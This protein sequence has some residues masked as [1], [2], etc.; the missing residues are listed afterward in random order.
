MNEE[1]KYMKRNLAYLAA[2][3]V[4]VGI[5]LVYVFVTKSQTDTTPPVIS[6]EEE[7]PEIS[8]LEQKTALLR[9]VTAYDDADGD[10]TESLV[11]ASIR[12]ADKEGLVQV[13]YAA[14]D[15]SGNVAQAVRQVVYKDYESPRFSLSAPLTLVQNH[16]VDIFSIVHAEDMFDGDISHRVR[17]TLLEGDS[18]NTVGVHQVELKVT[19]SLG[20]T[21]CL[22]VPVE[23]YA[24]GANNATLT[25]TDYF[26]YLPATEELDA[27]SYLDTYIKNGLSVSLKEG[28]PADYSL[29]I[30]NNVQYGVP[31][32]YTVEYRVMQ[33]VGV[34]ENAQN[35][36]GY[37]KLIVVVEG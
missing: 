21:V 33:T 32:V 20:E 16:N 3:L 18:I 26:V 10:V 15:A 22:V 6:F 12:L 13:T 4:C 5:F 27:E 25:L 30:E 34:G 17:I 7:M 37:A 19:N 9:G 8:A 11:V 28:L 23:V 29:E 24:S 14:F 35:Y 31:G 2:A 1:A 36:T